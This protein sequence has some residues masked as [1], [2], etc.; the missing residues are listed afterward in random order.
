MKKEGKWKRLLDVTVPVLCL[1]V[2]VTG[3][4]AFHFGQPAGTSDTTTAVTSI[5]ITEETSEGIPEETVDYAVLRTETCSLLIEEIYNKLTSRAM[6]D[7]A[8]ADHAASLADGTS[9][10]FEVVSL[11][12]ES[13]EFEDADLTDEAFAIGCYS[14]FEGK[15]AE[16]SKGEDDE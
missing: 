16:L 8:Y 13:P 6:P 5:P 11:I 7:G 12:I 2:A 15:I 4:E 10:I 1:S 3:C 9:D 14:A